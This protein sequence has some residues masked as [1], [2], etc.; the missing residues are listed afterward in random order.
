[1]RVEL[2]KISDS[3]RGPGQSGVT[4]T[5][6]VGGG[7]FSRDGGWGPGRLQRGERMTVCDCQ[8]DGGDRVR[9][10]HSDERMTV[11][12]CQGDRVRMNHSVG[13]RAMCQ[14]P[15]A[16]ARARPPPAR[17][18]RGGPAG[19]TGACCVSC[20]QVGPLCSQRTQTSVQTLRGP[21]RTA[22]AVGP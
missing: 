16:V 1:M 9:M 14:R 6:T 15:G 10:N 2:R 13:Q 20:T 5:L 7:C 19:E 18:P 21:T 17:G 11:C 8:G 4:A 3:F 22:G 12:D